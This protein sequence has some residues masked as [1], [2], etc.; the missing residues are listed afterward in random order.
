MESLP[1]QCIRDEGKIQWHEEKIERITAET[2]KLELKDNWEKRMRE[3]SIATYYTRLLL[4]CILIVPTIIAA[5]VFFF[6]FVKGNPR[7]IELMYTLHGIEH[8]ILRFVIFACWFVNLVSIASEKEMHSL[9]MFSRL[10]VNILFFLRCI[11]VLRIKELIY[12]Y[13]IF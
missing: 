9:D 6:F 7:K 8:L 2:I 13:F 11:I 5:Y 4:I 3:R 12:I 10:L 1:L